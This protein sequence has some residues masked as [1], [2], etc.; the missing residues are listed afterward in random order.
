MQNSQEPE[1][2]K[3]KPRSKLT[4]LLLSLSLVPAFILVK[5]WTLAA[6]IVATVLILANFGV[7]LLW[8]IT[9][10]TPNALRHLTYF[11]LPLIGL[12]VIHFIV[13]FFEAHYHH[14]VARND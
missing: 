9:Q 3:R 13:S 4:I 14:W 8:A 6:W 12:A 1:P 5:L 10:D 11:G 7:L 2:Q